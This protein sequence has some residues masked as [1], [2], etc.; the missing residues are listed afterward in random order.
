MHGDQTLKSEDTRALSVTELFIV[1]WDQDLP[2][3]W[4]HAL[5]SV[6]EMPFPLGADRHL[7]RS[8]E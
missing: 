8:R 6:L 4:A 7:A 2:V 5:K 3:D 1:S